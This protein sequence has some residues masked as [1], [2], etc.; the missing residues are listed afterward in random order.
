MTTSARWCKLTAQPKNSHWYENSL[1]TFSLSHRE[2]NLFLKTS[3]LIFPKATRIFLSFV[4]SFVRIYW[5]FAFSHL[6]LINMTNQ[7]PWPVRKGIFRSSGQSDFIPTTRTRTPSPIV[8]MPLSPPPITSQ[9]QTPSSPRVTITESP[10]TPTTP[11][12]SN[13]NSPPLP[14]GKPFRRNIRDIPI[15]VENQKVYFSLIFLI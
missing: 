13:S 7:A 6:F 3:R 15:E 5:R 9:P 12:Q 8:E 4:S 14:N 2:Q 11:R 1:F 10:Q